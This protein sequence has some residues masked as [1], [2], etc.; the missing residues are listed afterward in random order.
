MVTSGAVESIVKVLVAVALFPAASTALALNVQS[1]SERSS[2][3]K[4]ELAV[5]QD[6]NAGEPWSKEHVEVDPDSAAKT[7]VGRLSA[8]LPSGPE[9]T[10]IVGEIVS[11]PNTQVALAEIFPA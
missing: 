3:G 10:E 1:P 9:T 4:A 6:L 2:D 11:T 8:V 5:L 7:N